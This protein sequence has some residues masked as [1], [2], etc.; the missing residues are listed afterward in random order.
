MPH[1]TQV[2]ALWCRCLHPGG[3]AAP[4]PAAEMQTHTEGSLGKAQHGCSYQPALA[5][6]E[7]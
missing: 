6:S 5:S 4:P 1:E 7:A 3:T 2:W